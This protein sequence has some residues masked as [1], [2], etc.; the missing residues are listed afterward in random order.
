MPAPVEFS[1]ADPFFP[2]T[3]EGQDRHLR[4]LANA[5]RGLMDGKTNAA[6]DFS[7]DTGTATTTTVTYN[8]V[9]NTSRVI[10][11]PVDDVAATHLHAGTVR[12]PS[13]DISDG[14]FIV[15]HLP[16][17]DARNFRASVLS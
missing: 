11:T 15:T 5:V 3:E 17:P 14:S 9:R 2:K 13:A 10:L 1:S 16:Y 7:L 12:V 6:F 8:R 4:Q